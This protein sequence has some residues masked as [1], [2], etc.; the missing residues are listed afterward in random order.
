MTHEGKR[1]VVGRQQLEGMINSPDTSVHITAERR[2]RWREGG[3]ERVKKKGHV[4]KEQI[5]KRERDT[6]RQQGGERREKTGRGFCMDGGRTEAEE[7]GLPH[8]LPISGGILLP[9]AI[10]NTNLQG[11]SHWH[12]AS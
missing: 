6:R 7:E 5:D 11:H 8:R 3:R 10:S 9:S 4:V 1:V 12:C 2:D